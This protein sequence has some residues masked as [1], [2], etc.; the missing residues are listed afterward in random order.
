MLENMDCYVYDMHTGRLDDL[1]FAIKAL[2][3]DPLDSEKT[4]VVISSVLAWAKN[5]HKMVED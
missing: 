5:P 1:Q 3:R 2:T 4:L